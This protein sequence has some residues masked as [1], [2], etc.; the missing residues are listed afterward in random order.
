MYFDQRRK[1]TSS[2]CFRM[3]IDMSNTHMSDFGHRLCQEYGEYGG[4]I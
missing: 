3:D 1:T 2:M 4:K